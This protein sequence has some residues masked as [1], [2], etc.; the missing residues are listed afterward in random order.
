MASGTPSGTPE[1]GTLII[2]ALL[3]LALA[4]AGNWIFEYAQTGDTPADLLPWFGLAAAAII[5]VGLAVVIARGG[6]PRG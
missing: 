1:A 6:R 5:G 2:A 3:I 4:F